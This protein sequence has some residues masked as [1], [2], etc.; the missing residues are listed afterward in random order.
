MFGGI[1]GSPKLNMA[2]YIRGWEPLTIQGMPT[3]SLA[4]ATYEQGP[5]LACLLY[6]LIS[7][8]YP[9]WEA[10]V[11]HDGPGPIARDVVERINDPRI[12]L[13]ETQ[14]RKQQYGHPWRQDAIDKC[15]GDYIGLTNG[16]NYYIPVYFE[17]MLHTLTTNNG[18]LCYCD[19]LH[20]YMQWGVMRSTPVKNQIDLG[21]W[22]GSAALVKST[23]WSDNG[24]AGDGTFIED[25]RRRASRVY[26][27]ARPLFVHN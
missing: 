14:E 18:D 17:W 3:V 24:F 19:T 6:S 25:M 20:S 10:W 26:H 2:R 23:P 9:K 7:Q 1:A 4:I 8:T 13:I 21:C 27:I 16:D 22:I 15:R 5:E 11:W 12:H